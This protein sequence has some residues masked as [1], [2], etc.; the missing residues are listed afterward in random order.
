MRPYGFGAA[1]SIARMVAAASAARCAST[2]S[3]SSSARSIG[4]SP[5]RTRTSPSKRSSD[6]RAEAIASPVPRASCWTASVDVRR[7]SNASPPRSAA[8]TRPRPDRRRAA[9]RRRAP[10]RPSAGRA[11]G[12]D[13]SASPSAS[14]C[15]G[16]RPS[17]RLRGSRHA[18][19]V[20]A[21]APGFEPGITG[22]KPVALPLGYAPP[23]STTTSFPEARPRRR[24]GLLAVGPGR[25]GGIAACPVQGHAHPDRYET[26]LPR[27][28]PW[29]ER[30]PARARAQA[31]QAASD[32][33]QRR[34]ASRPK[35]GSSAR[36]AKP[37]S[38]PQ[39]VEGRGSW[40]N[41]GFPHAQRRSP[42]SSASARSARTASAMIASVPRMNAAIGMSATSTW[43][44]AAVQ[45]AC[46]TVS[47]PRAPSDDHVEEDD[48]RAD[49]QGEP[50][51]DHVED[52]EQALH[53]RDP[54]REAESALL[55]P[56]TG[57]ARA[58]VDDREL[59]RSQPYQAGTVSQVSPSRRSRRR[60]AS[61]SRR[62]E[63][64]P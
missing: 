28:C 32:A 10:S 23:V 12:A 22:P 41:H 57:P 38:G 24:P 9:A 59:H 21:G 8:S 60:A 58:V 54:D 63:N 44:I 14:A 27:P 56:A 3:A 7:E 48:D 2:S 51:G 4:V 11:A 39:P 53:H 37:L 49:D 43:D 13:A 31:N 16:R 46:A 52:D 26:P 40:G 30:P 42:S 55:Q 6:P 29:P 1:G 50:A 45:L 17:R 5:E 18:G 33:T 61:A 34:S 35:G 25:T 15:R 62:R 36:E 64:S 20:E 47:L 19:R